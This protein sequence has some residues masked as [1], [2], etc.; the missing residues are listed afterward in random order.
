M[1]VSAEG[2]HPAMHDTFGL[3]NYKETTESVYS[4]GVSEDM[5]EA[6]LSSE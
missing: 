5:I 2:K 1:N 6:R 3:G 4:F